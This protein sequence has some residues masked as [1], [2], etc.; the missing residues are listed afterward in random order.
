LLSNAL[1]ALEV[2]LSTYTTG[3]SHL[4]CFTIF[5]SQSLLSKYAQITEDNQYELKHKG[6]RPFDMIGQR[7][8]SGRICV[9]QASLEYRR[10][11]FKQTKE[12]SDGK[13]IFSFSGTRVLS[14]IPQLT[15]IYHENEKK[16]SDIDAFVKSCELSLSDCIR[17]GVLPSID[18]VEAIATC[19][20]RTS[21][22]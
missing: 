5:N 18:L 11:L 19:K 15:A 7:L 4:C 14:N 16:M 10:Q 9:A 22:R 6:V 21:S 2:Q 8:Y 12:Y 20:V 17:R 1:V 13:T 3:V